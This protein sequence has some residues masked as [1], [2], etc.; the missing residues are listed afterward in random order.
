MYKLVHYYTNVL[1][2]L[3]E[4]KMYDEGG[5]EGDVAELGTCERYYAKG[6]ELCCLDWN[7]LMT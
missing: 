4:R 2:W 6:K 1:R 5:V 3:H 7:A